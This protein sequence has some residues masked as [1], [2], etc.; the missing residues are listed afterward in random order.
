MPD[1][2][3]ATGRNAMGALSMQL[4]GAPDDSLVGKALRTILSRGPAWHGEPYGVYPFYYWYYGSRAAFR[5]GGEIWDEWKRA[6]CGML[7]RHQNGDGSWEL[8]DSEASKLDPVYGAAIGALIL[9]LCC[10][11]PP[12][13][14]RTDTAPDRPLPP[15]RNE[16]SVSI[17]HPLPRSRVHDEIEIRAVPVVPGRVTVERLAFILDGETIGER[18]TEPWTITADLGPGVKS[19]VFEVVAVSSLGQE[20]TARVVTE[21]GQNRVSVRIVRP[22]GQ[23]ILGEQ[24]IFVQAAGHP[25][26][27][28]MEVTIAVDGEEVFRGH[29]PPFAVEFDFGTIGGETIVATAVN[30]LDKEATD[31][32]TTREA[33]PLEVDI[34]ATVTDEANNYIL[35]LKQEDFLVQEDG[36]DQEILRFSREL[37][38]VSMVI[39]LDTS[40]SMR[41]HMKA[42]QDA[43]VQFV[44][45]IRDVDRVA[46]IAFSDNPRVV[47]RFTADIGALTRAIRQTAAKG[48]TCLYD[49]VVA[50]CQQLQREKGRTAIILLTDGKDEDKKGTGPGSRSTFEQALETAKETG[51]TIYSLGLGKG[52]AED[53]LEQLAKPTGG[54]AYFPP[55]VDDLAEVY[56]LVAK[57]LQSQYS[58]GYSSTNRVRDR[59]WRSISVTIPRTGYSVRTKDGYF[60]R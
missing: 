37:T 8:R 58:I 42:V 9:E 12:L 44:S 31:T 24:E 29:E 7:V 38:P 54:R 51:V 52:V 20:A 36:V 23:I 21:E 11:S 50:G 18:T 5:A 17:E 1:G 15:P 16:I 4:L 34:S 53:V 2:E 46:I 14:L 30:A 55:T 41:R 56:Q 32:V 33:P 28:L 3:V 22:R 6:M 13:Y 25:D 43:A 47:Q 57:E 59:A 35:N 45:Q 19:H 49:A 40:G 48:G 10:G 26:S 27:P 60:A 39:L